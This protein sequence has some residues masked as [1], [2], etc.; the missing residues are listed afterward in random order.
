M[1][2]PVDPT[3]RISSGIVAKSVGD[4]GLARSSTASKAVPNSGKGVVMSCSIERE[5]LVVGEVGD[6]GPTTC[7]EVVDHDDLVAAR[8][9]QLGEVR[10]DEAASAGEEMAHQRDVVRVGE[11]MSA[12][13]VVGQMG[14]AADFVERPHLGG[15][16]R[17]E[18]RQRRTA[19]LGVPTGV[20]SA[21]R[22]A[23]AVAKSWSMS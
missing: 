21:D 20:S 7:C 18:V 11:G 3:A 16:R 17:R 1:R 12:S 13:G 15:G 5:A 22:S 6:V 2:V 19:S 4:A 14:A 10:A 23:V 9:E 8:E